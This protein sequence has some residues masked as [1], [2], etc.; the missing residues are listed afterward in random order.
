METSH[1]QRRRCPWRLLRLSSSCCFNFVGLYLQNRDLACEFSCVGTCVHTET[2][3]A[4]GGSPSQPL[5]QPD[6]ECNAPLSSDTPAAKKM[7]GRDAHSCPPYSAWGDTA[8]P[9]TR[10]PG[11][12][13][14]GAH[15]SLLSFTS[16]GGGSLETA[17]TQLLQSHGAPSPGVR[18][19]LREGIK[20]WQSGYCPG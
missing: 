1:F 14:A 7:S 20:P 10:C 6:M 8:Q 12:W 4:V 5:Q 3:H 11:P 9:G 19:E 18:K 16:V 17:Q 15:P 2:C 13:T